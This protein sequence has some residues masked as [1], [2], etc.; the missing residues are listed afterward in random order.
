MNENLL[1]R[2]RRFC[3]HIN[4]LPEEIVYSDI[5]GVSVALVITEGVKVLQDCLLDRS[6]L[7]LELLSEAIR[8]HCEGV[9]L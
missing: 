5:Q 1:A 8:L 9:E 7:L 3:F 6:H 2:I 4:K